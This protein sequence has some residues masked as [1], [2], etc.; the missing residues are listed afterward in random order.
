MPHRPLTMLS[1]VELLTPKLEEAVAFARDI[2]G[3]FVVEEC[4][5]PGDL[6]CWGDY[7][8]YSLVLTEGPEPALGHSAW[9]S[10]NAEQLDVAV[11]SVEAHGLRGEGIASSFRHG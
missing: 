2:L 3:L 5:G 6:R 9:R 8:A 10:W 7:C 4:E 11:A 1:H